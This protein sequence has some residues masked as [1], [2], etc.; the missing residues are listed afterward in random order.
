MNFFLLFEP[1]I[2]FALADYSHPH[3]RYLGPSIFLIIISICL[4]IESIKNRLTKISKNLTYFFLI[5]V[6]SSG[7][8]KINVLV[9]TKKLVDKKF[10]QYEILDEFENKKS[11]FKLPYAVYRENLNTLR[12]YKK[13]LNKKIISL[14]SG[15][16]NKK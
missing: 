6:I 15:A 9:E 2:L 14:N 4:I 16:D 8:N 11:L 13:L 10:I 7:Y 3:I 1:I 12:L 5:I